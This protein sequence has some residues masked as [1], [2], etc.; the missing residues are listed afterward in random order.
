M[1][2]ENYLLTLDKIIPL[3]YEDVHSVYK[4]NIESYKVKE[5]SF[6]RDEFEELF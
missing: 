3:Y 6:E 5:L 1:N 2:Y 4:K